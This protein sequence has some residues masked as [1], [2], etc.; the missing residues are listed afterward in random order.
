[1]S[2]ENR[3]VFLLENGWQRRDLDLFVHEDYSPELVDLEEAFEIQD[4]FDPVS[5]EEY[6]F[7]T[8]MNRKLAH[9]YAKYM[10]S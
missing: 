9:V 8:N 6:Y 3:I 1:M 5:V 2:N 4:R 7:N 10:N